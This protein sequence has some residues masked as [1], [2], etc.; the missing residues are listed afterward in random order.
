MRCPPG[1]ASVNATYLSIFS[2]KEQSVNESLPQRGKA[3]HRETGRTFYYATRLLPKRI[4]QQTYV[5][6]GFFR[7]AD[8]IVDGESADSPDT[9]RDHLESLRAAA[10]GEQPTDDPVVSA[11][12][13]VRSE[14]DIPRTE[15]DYFIDSMITDLEKDRYETFD[16]LDSYMR[17]SAGAVGVMM[18]TIMDATDEQT[19]AHA[20]ALGEAFQ[21]TNFA[22]DVSEDITDLDRLYIPQSLLDEYGVSESD[23]RSGRMT[24][25]I[26]HVIQ[27]FLDR[28]ER[29]YK[30]G[31]RGIDRL[32]ED[33]Q[34]PVLLAAV[35]Y[36]E[37][38]RLIRNREYD[39]LSSRPTLSRRRKLWTLARTYWHWRR[40]HEPVA[41]FGRVS[42]VRYDESNDQQGVG[43][44]SDSKFPTTD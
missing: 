37:H 19:K 38:H 31:V 9:K 8:E 23:L 44:H 28:A 11:F 2:A 3:I 30:N 7:I 34:F 22:R 18:A 43:L 33:C 32:P 16:E 15:V 25:N 1:V 6:Y 39:V 26:R 5:L 4:R 41:V 20:M 29:R 17:G 13:D 40:I 36:A 14:A 21:L 27:A 35:L 24:S 12:G 42:A 10:L